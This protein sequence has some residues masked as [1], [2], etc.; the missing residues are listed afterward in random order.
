MNMTYTISWLSCLFPLLVSCMKSDKRSLYL[1]SLFQ[2]TLCWWS[3][4][5][6]KDPDRTSEVRK[7]RVY[8]TSC[9]LIL[10]Q[11]QSIYPRLSIYDRQPAGACRWTEDDADAPITPGNTRMPGSHPG[12]DPAP[13]D[14]EEDEE[15]TAPSSVAA[16]RSA[17][18]YSQYN[19]RS[20]NDPNPE[21]EREDSEPGSPD[22]DDNSNDSGSNTASDDENDPDYEPSSLSSSLASA[23]RSGASTQ[24][25]SRPRN[26]GG[27]ASSLWSSLVSSSPSRR[28]MP[29][30]SYETRTE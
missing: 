17:S 6:P 27:E 30:L 7:Y 19:F 11:G 12:T 29:R 1:N 21:P 2:V 9:H 5:W 8:A 24:A 20:R 15:P 3:I 14:L 22:N 23:V 4:D 10:R 13:D 25:G 28:K 18:S 26:R 16:I